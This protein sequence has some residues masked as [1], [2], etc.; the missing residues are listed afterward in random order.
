V[1][2]TITVTAKRQVVLPKGMCER[3][4]IRPGTSLRITE[5]GDGF[6]VAP[7]PEPTAAELAAVL[8]ALDQGRR[9]R[10]I[11]AADEARIREAVR[12][13]RLEN[14]RRRT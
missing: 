13:Y 4:S 10:S 14:R 1:T 8:K 5:V 7:V 12:R 11:T 2:T 9:G 6:Y 3:R